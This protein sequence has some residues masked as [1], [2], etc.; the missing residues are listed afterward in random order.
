MPA[1]SDWLR[2]LPSKDTTN[3]WQDFKSTVSPPRPVPRACPKLQESALSVFRQ[4][5][6]EAHAIWTQ[7]G[8]EFYRATSQD[9]VI[10]IDGGEYISDQASI[11]RWR[12]AFQN[13]FAARMDWTIKDFAHANHNP[14]LVVNGQPGSSPLELTADAKQ[15]I[16]LDAVGST[17]PDGQPLHYKWWVYEEAG[18]AGS[19]GADIAIDNPTSQRV[20]VTVKSPCR[21]PWLPGILPCRGEGVAHVILEVTDEGSPNLT[22]YRRVILHIRPLLPDPITKR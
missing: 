20:Q 17:D 19:H 9:R 13:D 2:F 7:G 6:G 10:G 1:Q 12:K 14:E 22:S 21:E 5:Y 3:S 15:T 8:D 4:P 11:W 16:T 18:L